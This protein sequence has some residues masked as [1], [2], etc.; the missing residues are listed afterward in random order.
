MTPLP[1]VI[2]IGSVDPVGSLPLPPG[3][4]VEP[5]SP[6]LLGWL[7]PPLLPPLLLPP[8]LSPPE[9]ED[10]DE[11]EP[12]APL[13][14]PAVEPFDPLLVLSLLLLPPAAPDA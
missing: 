3:E 5:G 12:F 13:E 8:E 14:C 11:P 10:G 1:P 9:G 2:I 4:V 7:P 6:P